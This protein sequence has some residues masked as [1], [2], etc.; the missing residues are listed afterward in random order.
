MN[1]FPYTNPYTQQHGGG[2]Q[3]RQESPFQHRRGD[4]D[5]QQQPQHEHS[6]RRG[7]RGGRGDGADVV[8]VDRDDDNDNR[9]TRC[10]GSLQRLLLEAEESSS[11]STKTRDCARKLRRYVR[12]ERRQQCDEWSWTAVTRLVDW[13]LRHLKVAVAA[14]AGSEVPH[15]GN[16]GGR[17][18]RR[19]RWNPSD[20]GSGDDDN[21]SDES[22]VT[23][24]AAVEVAVGALSVLSS[25][26]ELCWSDSQ[27][28]AASTY[29]CSSFDGGDDDDDDGEDDN[30][31]DEGSSSGNT[32]LQVVQN[33]IVFTTK[34]STA[35]GPNRQQIQTL[36]S[37]AMILLATLWRS[38][39][40]LDRFAFSSSSSPPS[41]ANHTA[42]SSSSAWWMETSTAGNEDDEEPPS[43]VI[44][45]LALRRLLRPEDDSG[46]DGHSTEEVQM[47]CVSLLTQL[48]QYEHGPSLR[49]SSSNWLLSVPTEIVE[50]LVE[51]RLRVQ[52][53]R[54]SDPSMPLTSYTHLSIACS[55][56]LLLAQRFNCRAAS[57]A[58][59]NQNF[60]SILEHIVRATFGGQD[61]CTDSP[62]SA[63][64][65][66]RNTNGDDG[67][68]SRALLHKW[69][70]PVIRTWLECDFYSASKALSSNLSS[71]DLEQ[72]WSRLIANPTSERKENSSSSLRHLVSRPSTR[73]YHN[74]V[75][76]LGNYRTPTREALSASLGRTSIDQFI[77]MLV[78]DTAKNS[79]EAAMLLR[80]L[81]D[82]RRSSIT[83]DGLSRTLW[84][85][86]NP[87][88][89]S[90]CL[91]LA[92]SLQSAPSS[93]SCPLLLCLLDILH[94]LTSSEQDFCRSALSSLSAQSV[95]A[96]VNLM[97]PKTMK[98]DQ[99][100]VMDTSLASNQSDGSTPPANN[101][102]RIDNSLSYSE[103]KQIPPRGIDSTV[104]MATATV[105]ALLG[106]FRG[107]S[108][109]EEAGRVVLLQGR[110]M[111]A[112][113]SFVGD[114][115]MSFSCSP[116]RSQ[117][118]VR[119]RLRLLSVLTTSEN[120]D[121]LSTLLH[122]AE[123]SHY[124][125]VRTM[126]QDAREYTKK[127]KRYEQKEKHLRAEKE[128]CM[129]KLSAQAVAFQRQK[130]EYQRS[131]AQNAKSLVQVHHA[132]RA[133]A[134][135]RSEDLLEK[136]RG[137]E[138]R[139][140]ESERVAESSRRAELQ[141]KSALEDARS[142][143]E[144]LSLS[145]NEAVQRDQES[146][147]K[148]IQLAE[149]L[150]S[151][152]SRLAQMKR[153]EEKMLA[154]IGVQKESLASMEESQHGMQESLETLFADM[155]SLAQLYQRLERN[156]KSTREN[157]EAGQQKM[158]KDIDALRLRYAELEEK[159]KQTECQNEMLSRKYE[160]T[161]QKLVKEREERQ[162]DAIDRRRR[163][164]PVSYINQL[165]NDSTTSERHF[166]AT[167]SSSRSGAEKENESISS[168]SVSTAHRASRNKNR[169][170]R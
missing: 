153:S 40:R 165:H 97:T 11:S 9:T 166:K 83:H 13:T 115:Q 67:S 64:R 114:M 55:Q 148:L 151:A 94:L 112:V 80:T 79:L 16:S 39:E 88:I 150:R 50:E 149:E 133:K 57:A 71:D 156:E 125:A 116:V 30:G 95:E 24:K 105:L 60:V 5:R 128:S 168:S 73:T 104:R 18:E 102:S 135:K 169:N 122:S 170:Y 23:A 62:T 119:R 92:A 12:Q 19:R 140:V 47:A 129:E 91:E 123:V 31:G 161:R 136:M 27:V 86:L 81:L 15:G 32:L 69:T 117:D 152:K 41:I 124:S 142:E 120:E 162:K 10:S 48:A 35:G 96:L 157:G 28:Y 121:Y 52:A 66:S 110:M 87:T 78:D 33:L 61:G 144:K 154:K 3:R 139:L 63:P 163:A 43:A 132:E 49:D 72:T 7:G 130:S 34:V 51:T 143:I 38:F 164:G 25:A 106:E 84:Q 146:T 46:D 111:D 37:A 77:R 82:D 145:E 108:D 137:M 29:S 75:F 118:M 103:M 54:L 56:L 100:L 158:K 20:G 70:L 68:P 59:K 93:A 14:A 167:T 36:Q 131:T 22:I 147:K 85:N 141:S 26:A 134:E 53:E 65:W 126:Q 159:Y 113:H 6:F 90:E 21:D 74:L 76:L 138:K 45:Q 89:V 127:I 42:R 2:G 160:K 1:A 17:E 58:T 8:D 109:D 107:S 44:V 101:L 99:S 155:V 4:H 98:G